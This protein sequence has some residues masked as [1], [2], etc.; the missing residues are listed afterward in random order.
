MSYEDNLSEEEEK[1]FETVLNNVTNDRNWCNKNEIEYGNPN[2]ALARS[3]LYQEMYVNPAFFKSMPR[4]GEGK[5]PE[6]VH[7]NKDWAK[8]RK[9]PRS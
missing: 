9:N 3:V 8:Y 1:E 7:I 4:K 2:M 6:R 5:I